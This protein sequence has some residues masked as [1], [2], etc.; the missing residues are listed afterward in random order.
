MGEKP[1]R[2]KEMS[3]KNY[4]KL[5]PEEAHVILRKGT[6]APFTGEYNEHFEEGIYI[7]RQCEA[8]LYT[9]LDKFPSHCGWPS[10]DLEVPGAVTRSLDADGRR[11]E[12]LCAN[13]GGHLGHVFTGERLTQRDTRHCVNSL[14]LRFISCERAIFAGGCFWGV[15]YYL[16]KL[17]GVYSVSSGYTGGQTENPSYE[18]VCRG[19]TGHLEAVL[20]LYNPQEISY[21]ELT[22]N[23]FEIHDPSQEGRQGPDV[24]E[25]YS[26]A[27]FYT[28]N[29]Q[30]ETAHKLIAQLEKKGLKVATQLWPAKVFYQ[31]EDYHQ[32]YYEKK[33]TKPYCHGYTKRF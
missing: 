13:C 21:E 33:G 11:T 1:R 12:I 8:P 20:V 25:Q 9:S 26:S 2:R 16:K 22:K 23:F 27:I 28:H 4:N 24:G 6:E 18:E 10:F 31:A 32:G 17:K 3:L 15:E 14:S 19:N 29:S 7:C 5:S 30:K